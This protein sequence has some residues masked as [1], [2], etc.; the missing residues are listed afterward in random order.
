MGE[1]TAVQIE[2]LDADLRALQAKLTADLSATIE[3]AR[4]VDLD[5]PIGRVSRMDAIQQQSMVKAGRRNLTRR[6]SQVAAALAAI[7]RGEYGVCR[8]CE[9]PVGYARLKARPETPY[10][11]QCQG[12]A[13]DRR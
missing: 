11:L 12:R 10:C 8:R 13:E 1:L 2:Q 3:G 6:A 4:P 7:D 9:E 5:Q